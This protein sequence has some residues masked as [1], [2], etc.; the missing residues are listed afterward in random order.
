LF[1]YTS[2]LWEGVIIGPKENLIGIKD[3][4]NYQ[5]KYK[6]NIIELAKF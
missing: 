5:W 4:N 6:K 1:S 2:W 3:A